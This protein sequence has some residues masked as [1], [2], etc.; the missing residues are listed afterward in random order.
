MGD[1]IRSIDWSKTPVGPISAWPLSLK[2]SV[3]TLLDCQLPMNISWGKDLIQFYND[4][5]R[6]ILGTKK[7]PQAMG[8]PAPQTWHEIWPTIGPMW[9]EV[10]SGK[11]IGFNDFKLTIDRNGYPE[12]CYFNFSYSPVRDDDGEIAGLMVT[13][14]ETTE[15]VVSEQ[16]LE[17][18]REKL[19]SLF[20][21]A[22]VPICIFEGPQHVYKLANKHYLELIDRTDVVGKPVREVLPELEGQG[23]FEGLDH[24]F[25]TKQRFVGLVDFKVKTQEGQ[26]ALRNYEVIWEPWLNLAGDAEGIMV[27]ALDITAQVSARERV[28]KLAYE[29]DTANIAKTR[30]LANMSHEIRTPLGAMLG[31]T[32]LLKDNSLSASDRKTYHE[33]VHRSGHALTELIGDI[34]DFSK[35]ES[36]LLEVE[37]SPLHL[38][39]LVDEVA[40]LLR[41]KAEEKSLELK[42][43]AEPGVPEVILSDSSRLRQILINIVGNAIKFTQQGSITLTQKIVRNSDG[44]A[45]LEFTVAD[46]GCGILKD[47]QHRLFRPFTQADNSM[48]RRFG[49]TG[50]GLELSRRLA[51]ALG[52]TVKLQ[53][54]TPGVGSTFVITVAAGEAEVPQ[55][56]KPLI[57]NQIAVDDDELSLEGKTV[58]VVDDSSDNQLLLQRILQRRKAKTEVASNGLEALTKTSER[59]FDFI[60]MDI[61]MPVMDGFEATTKLRAKGYSK[62][63]IALTAH[64]TKEDRAKSLAAGCNDHLTKPVNVLN[65]LVCLKELSPAS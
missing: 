56:T 27:V 33:I 64:A 22:P 43:I 38:Q 35:I 20:M 25:K 58:L 28:E 34:L 29:A 23:A 3:R 26:M 51:E 62:P 47:Q 53:S 39:K 63:I 45:M 11:P 21:Q 15:R 48:T 1:L 19:H 12:D 46:T 10:L 16:K 24:V 52:G 65:L 42:I 60:L 32:E 9:A 50:L 5:Y 31:F 36:G 57:K 54:S 37:K 49:G 14:A 41:L 61:Q 59:D 4:A 8:T 6:P 7:H 44:R 17:R 2:T 13:F 18:E 40:S 30:F 55:P